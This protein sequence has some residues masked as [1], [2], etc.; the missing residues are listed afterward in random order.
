ML[1]SQIIN[2]YTGTMMKAKK[3]K[4]SIVQLDKAVGD[5]I[6]KLSVMSQPGDSNKDYGK[7]MLTLNYT[8]VQDSKALSNCYAVS[9]PASSI[10]HCA[11]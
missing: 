6:P 10:D 7:H 5:I 9:L 2:N 11:R 4:A 8:G 3:T 1:Q